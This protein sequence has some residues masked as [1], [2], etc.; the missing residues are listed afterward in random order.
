MSRLSFGSWR[1]F[2]IWARKCNGGIPL[3]EVMALRPST[4]SR[5]PDSSAPRRPVVAVKRESDFWSAGGLRDT[6]D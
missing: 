1:S 3:S 4:Y 5:A 6:L 2:Q